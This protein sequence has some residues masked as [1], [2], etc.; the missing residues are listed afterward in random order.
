MNLTGK[1]IAVTG[2][3]GALGSAI[4]KAVR[5]AGGSVAAIDRHAAGQALRELEGVESIAGVDLSKP[6]QASDALRA[7]AT[8][9]GGLDG[10]VN[11]A[12]TFRWETIHP[13]SCAARLEDKP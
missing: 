8:R 9:L 7:A 12:G 2:A 13:R 10:L 6:Q 3:S 5:T 4:V 11:V 1:K